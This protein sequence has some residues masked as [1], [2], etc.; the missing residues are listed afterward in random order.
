VSA[1]AAGA[2]GPEPADGRPGDAA[3]PGRSVP[4]TATQAQR[5]RELGAADAA[6]AQ[7]FTDA[8]ARNAAFKRLEDELTRAGRERL[9]ALRQAQRGPQL[10]EL[11][12]TLGA[13][14]RGAGFVQVV[15]PH[16]IT[17]ESLDK[18]GIEHGH[19]LREQ[20]FWLDDRHCLRPMLAPNLY[21]LLRRLGRIYTR[22]FGIVEIG[23][24]FRRD[25]KGASHLNEFTMMNL[26]ELGRPQDQG[27]A[28]LEELAALVMAA[29][30]IAAYDLV[31]TD[32]E[33]YGQ[34]L[35]VEVDG[36]EVCSATVGPLPMDGNWGIVEPWVGL[37]FGLERLLM[38]RDA[39]TSIERVGRSVNYLDAVRLNI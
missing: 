32:S 18:M 36:S 10:V 9:L 26:V 4:F 23:A 2:A 33:V 30:G 17:G 7:G 25:T 5:L 27:R 35:D 31:P 20:V 6:A 3:D 15:T 8:A 24:C 11:T 28:R 1:A 39:L 12:A 16:I 34:M 14:V 21:T 19:P 38:A 13:A 29:A 22:P 37:G